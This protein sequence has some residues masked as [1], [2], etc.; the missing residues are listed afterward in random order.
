MHMSLRIAM[1]A[2]SFIFAAAA[3]L[4]SKIMFLS[5]DEP[6]AVLHHDHDAVHHSTCTK[7]GSNADVILVKLTR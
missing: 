4:F 5:A 3:A 1:H 7:T 2:E 6:A